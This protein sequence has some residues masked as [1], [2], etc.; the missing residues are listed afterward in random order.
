MT[1]PPTAKVDGPIPT[2]GRISSVPAE[3]LSTS[4]GWQDGAYVLQASGVMREATAFGTNLQLTR[5]ITAALGG[6]S[7]RISDEIENLSTRPSPLMFCYHC[8]PGFPILDGPATRLALHSEY[9]FDKDAPDTALGPETWGRF[10]PP[11]SHTDATLVDRVWYHQ[12]RAAADGMV[13]LVLHCRAEGS[14]ALAL[15]FKYP[16]A[17]MAQLTTWSHMVAGEYICGLEPGNAN[18]LGR[19]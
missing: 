1:L 8:N 14:R 18:M 9:S 15:Y 6:N 17:E 10:A 4:A 11:G 16:A 13:T 7:F 12:P 3:R 19:E 2:H 5:T